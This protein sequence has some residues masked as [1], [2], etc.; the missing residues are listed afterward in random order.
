M[1]NAW[2]AGVG[3]FV[4]SPRIF[5]I[6]L[7]FI[8]MA[9]VWL[10]GQ[11][12][13]WGTPSTQFVPWWAQAYRMLAAGELPLWNPLVGGGAPLLANYQSALLYP[14]TWIY[15]LLAAI[16]GVSLMAWGQ[17]LLL[18]AHLAW[19]GLG[20][21]RLVRRLGHSPLAQTV[22][23][24]A[25][26]MSGYLV[27]RAHFLSIN[28]AV[29]WLPWILLTAYNLVY[30]PDRRSLLWL[31]AALAL[32]WLAGHAQIATYTLLLVVAWLLF[33]SWRAEERWRIWRL[34]LSA[35]G[36]AL[37]LSA[38]QLLPTLEYLL[39]SQR[40]AS[41]DPAGA[42]TYSFWPWRLIALFAPN[43]FGNPAHNNY[44][45]YGNFWEDAIYVG[46]LPLL[47]ALAA[48]WVLRRQSQQ[49]RLLAFLG[50]L[51]VLSLLLALGDNTPIFPWLFEHVPGFNLF[52]SPA[53]WTIWLVIALA[54][55]SAYGVDA[56]RRPTGRALY[57]SR[58]AVAGS[59]AVIAVAA[60]GLWLGDRAGLDTPLTFFSA[61]LV[62]GLLALAAAILHL[63]APLKPGAPPRRSA[64]LVVF[65]LAA[66]LLYAGWGL[67]PGAP[68]EL[69]AEPPADY[70]AAQ[71]ALGD[72]R[73]YLPPGTEQV[74]KFEQLFRFDGFRTGAEPRAIFD[75][76]VPNTNLLFGLASANNYDPF[77]PARYQ[78]WLDALAEAEPGQRAKLLSLLGVNAIERVESYEPMRISFEA[79]A[80]L[81][82]VGWF[83]CP[84]IATSAESAWAALIQ[85]DFDPHNH[86]IVEI[87]NADPSNICGSDDAESS[88]QLISTAANRVIVEIQA[89]A[90]GWL[91]L[92]DTYYPGWGAYVDGVE[93]PVYPAQGLL[94]A[95]QLPAGTERVEFVYEPKSF[96][97]GVGL[98]LLGL[99]LSLW[100]TRRPRTPVR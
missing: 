29:A 47:L 20:M 70:A 100:A 17:G 45:G 68:R 89:P 26:G 3:R 12:L 92:A 46:Q 23:G 38:A 32:Q 85:D 27:A 25:F 7:P 75:S 50:A 4:R 48:I 98:T 14:P 5:I 21:S 37:L 61:S 18:A 13:Y 33:W 56:W 63:N 8:L 94:R 62:F 60:G 65:L 51:S 42:F 97:V 84:H 77:V 34:A 22:A 71:V 96:V 9:P 91:L 43:F 52:Q 54:L 11:A 87:P 86:L 64:W 41:V 69:Y 30:K 82:R 78:A 74:L 39:N 73:L 28:A 49:R 40:A 76:L 67:N 57:W 58:L 95:V 99:A 24:L 6:L 66:D 80:G 1:S 90:G 55:L 72:G 2:R 93:R 16:G 36:L 31:A 81:P 59:G 35:G 19:A 83:A 44:W 88:A 53:R 15:F 10:P 79:H